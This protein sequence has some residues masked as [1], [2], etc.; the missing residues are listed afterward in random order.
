MYVF[1]VLSPSIDPTL[2]ARLISILAC[3]FVDRFLE[4][5]VFCLSLFFFF[6]ARARSCELLFFQYASSLRAF[7][8]KW[9]PSV[10]RKGIAGREV[11]RPFAEKVDK[12]K[13]HAA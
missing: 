4:R 1:V 11:T 3:V 12:R 8:Y 2:N 9:Q 13:K 5:G 7:F 6:N 10:T